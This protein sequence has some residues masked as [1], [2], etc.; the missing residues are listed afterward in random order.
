LQ[1]KKYPLTEIKMWNLLNC[2]LF[3]FLSSI[4][5]QTGDDDG[6]ENDFFLFWNLCA[7]KKY[8]CEKNR[9]LKNK[10]RA[11]NFVQFI[12]FWRECFIFIYFLLL[13]CAS[14][15]INKTSYGLCK[16][17]SGKAHNMFACDL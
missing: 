13:S 3:N 7:G 8:K 4:S 6:D 17:A 9:L 16:A 2:F 1:T 15:H 14:S 5:P 12:F 10:K 11:T